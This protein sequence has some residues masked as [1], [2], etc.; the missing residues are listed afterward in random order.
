MTI[1]ASTRTYSLA[2]YLD[3]EAQAAEKH[4]FY[5][6]KIVKVPGGT[7][8]HNAIALRI[9]A[10]LLRALDDLETRYYVFNSDMKLYIPAWNQSLYPDAVVVCE[11]VEFY[12]GRQDLILNP[13]LIVE[14][15]SPSTE[16]Y[17]REPKFI[18]Y[19]SL[20]SFREYVLVRQDQPEITASYRREPNVW[21]DTHA[22][23]LEAVLNLRSVPAK[24]ELA[25]VY[26]G[27]DFA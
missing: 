9:G 5:N 26:K 2:E 3:L 25:K 27:I 10:L 22:Q 23:G 24:L 19:K 13:L 6:G 14:V 11:Q 18:K 8:Y 17:D 12:E 15:L 4:E 20:P 21:E 16:G 7:I 1:P